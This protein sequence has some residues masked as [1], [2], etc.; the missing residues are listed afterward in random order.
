MR[1]GKDKMSN[2][3]DSKS[4][5][6]FLKCMHYGKKALSV[7]CVIINLGLG[8]YSAVAGRNSNFD[9]LDWKIIITIIIFNSIFLIGVTI[10]QCV[11]SVLGRRAMIELQQTSHKFELNKKYSQNLLDYSH[12]INLEYNKEYNKIE[13]MYDDFRSNVEDKITLTIDQRLNFNNENDISTIIADIKNFRKSIIKTF[14]DFLGCVSNELK[15]IIDVALKQ[16][17]IDL[18]CAV[19]I[20][21]MDSKLIKRNNYKNVKII[22]CYRDRES[23]KRREVSERT[24]SIENNTDFYKCLQ[25]DYFLE[26]NLIGGDDNYY[27]ENGD[28][29]S[30]YNCTMVVPIFGEHGKHRCYFGYLACD[31][32]NETNE[33]LEVFDKEMIK[34]MEITAI[35]LGGYFDEHCN[36]WKG[37]MDDLK[38]LKSTAE[39]EEKKFGIKINDDF[40]GML[41]HMKMN[42]KNQNNRL[43]RRIK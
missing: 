1:I 41:Y 6:M 20:K 26:N 9:G 25:H 3:K 36:L 23:Y 15:S 43:Y 33:N 38:D 21:Q 40:V 17:G 42:K 10:H 39:I 28:F 13:E 14:D 4:W 12:Y 24:Y 22:T 30:Y 19:S 35:L 32:L 37:A 7:L 16:K 18:A 34:I 31:V 2:Y 8:I 5:K 29:L 11:I 27:N